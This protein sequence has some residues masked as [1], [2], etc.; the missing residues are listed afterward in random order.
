MRTSLVR[1]VMVVA[2]A[3]AGTT[4]CA[5]KGLVR[6]EVGKVSTKVDTLSQALEAT[7]ERS[8]QNEATIKAVD[9][10]A[11]GAQSA[12][13]D[14][15]RSATA[16]D[17][18]AVAAAS[19]AQV[20]GDAAKMAAD[21]ANAVDL[22]SKRIM[23]TVVLSEDEGGFKFN[24]AALPKEA[25]ARIDE[26]IAGIKADPK[27]AHFEI[28]GHTDNVGTKGVNER[29]G[30]ERAETVKRYLYEQHQIPLHRINVISYGQAKPVAPNTTK[31][32]RAQNRR[33][34][35]RVLA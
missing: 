30:V 3:A 35:I 15:Q 2:I 23:Y 26:M 20:A 25:K 29:I 18:K 34:V 21:K 17:A 5:T 19:T 13:V 14:A 28:E 22:A 7:Q 10:K 27:G 31:A 12:A 33:I 32:G 4:A 8:R 9:A 1:S 24:T 11:E 6:T 16:A